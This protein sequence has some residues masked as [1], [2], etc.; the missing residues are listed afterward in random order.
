[1]RYFNYTW[2]SA[3][4]LFNQTLF[5]QP[6]TA[7]IDE[8]IDQQLP[9]ATVGVLIKDAQTGEVIYSRNANK[10]LSPASSTK[11]FTAAA[12]LYYLKPD[13]RFSTSLAQK[14]PNYYLTFTGSPSLT[15]D[16]LAALV[17]N[18]KKNNTKVIQGNIIID[19][20][21]YPAPY[22]LNG[23]SYDDLG[24]GYTAP[25]TAV[26]LNEN[27]ERYQLTSA[28]KLGG[29]TQIKLKGSSKPNAKPT[30]NALTLINEVV[31]VS[32]EEEK[33]HCS[34]HIEIK[35]NNTLRLYGCMVQDKNPKLLEFAIPD[36]V[37]FA[38]QVIQSTLKK[39]GIVLKGKIIT[40]T[41]PADAQII[42]RYQSGDLSK[43]LKHMLQK[44]DNLY[45]NNIS[46]KLG[47]LLTGKGTHKEG[48]FAMKKI[49]S[50]HTHLDMKQMELADGEGTRYNLIAAEQFVDLLTQLYR[51]KNLQSALLNAL[52]QA[53]VS[54]TLQGRM[55]DSILN[56]K[57][58]AKT[59]SMHDLSS[60]SGF[61]I[62]PN[63]KTF[64]FSIISNGV[65]KSNAKAKALEEK[66]LST[67][68]EYYLEHSSREVMR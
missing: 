3:L 4:A 38:K 65:G 13:F 9:R 66:I 8:I 62:N 35:D 63:A 21:Q 48:M 27:A 32:K 55:K 51:D 20:S 56:K 45:A 37:L 16:N 24:W 2:I 14:G 22:Y 17:A 34:M 67:V 42:E 19:G 60:L 46:R 23:D 44:S 11:L 1:M 31:T 40:G 68:D 54:G 7:K 64:V 12:A 41:T 53:G 49:I 52:P 30:I 25:D 58:F 39:E 10:L 26:V 28:P 15:A 29:V 36:P 5:A 59:G 47:Y 18:L 50:E 61:I 33:N 43:L 6:L 57:V